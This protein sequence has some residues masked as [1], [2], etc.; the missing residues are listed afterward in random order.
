MNPAIKK[1]C[2]AAKQKHVPKLNTAAI[3][4]RTLFLLS[5]TAP[6]VY[7]GYIALARGF[8][9]SGEASA[10]GTGN[11]LFQIMV[12]VALWALFFVPFIFAWA[13]LR[14]LSGKNI[15]ERFA[16]TLI[17]DNGILRYG[18][19]IFMQS[20][21]RDR[22]VVQFA[23]VDIQ[24]AEYYPLTRKTVLCGNFMRAYYADYAAGVLRG[25]NMEKNARFVI[26]DYFNPSLLKL[27]ENN[28][29]QIT[30]KKEGE[31]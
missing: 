29:V 17:F 11:I 31:K 30:K 8:F 2:L 6:V 10:V 19:R 15:T 4:K 1:E 23:L 20:S 3:V 9:A 25:E 7:F 5:L 21:P 22:V 18:Y 24:S 12:I 13:L 16:E 27:L 28:K 14:N 26:Y